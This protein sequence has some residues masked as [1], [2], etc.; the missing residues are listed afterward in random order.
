MYIFSKRLLYLFF[1]C[2]SFFEQ[3]AQ[4]SGT[5]TIPGSYSTVAAAIAD[6]NSQGVNG[7]V[8]MQVAAGY[9]ET[10]PTGGYMLTATGT[11]TAPITFQRSGI[12][13][14]PLIVAF[15]GSSTSFSNTVDCIW[16]M[17]G[18]D[19]LTIDGI[20]LLDTATS[21]PSSME[22]G[23]VFYK[24]D[25]SDGCR[26]NTVKN[27][28][29]QLSVAT[30]SNTGSCGIAFLNSTYSTN[31]TPVGTSGLDGASSYNQIFGN[32]ISKVRI[33]ITMAGASSYN[34][35]TFC[36]TGNDIGGMLAATGNTI[37]NFGGGTY[38]LQIMGV[39]TYEQFNLNL[40]NNY[41]D[42][43]TGSWVTTSGSID[44]IQLNNYRN[45]NTTILNNTVSVKSTGT[46]V[47]VNGISSADLGVAN[48]SNVLSINNNLLLNCST[49]STGNSNLTGIKTLGSPFA[50]EIKNNLLS[51]FSGS[52][53]VS[54]MLPGSTTS[55]SL[56]SN[57]VSNVTFNGQCRAVAFVSGYGSNSLT[58]KQNLFEDFV[59]TGTVNIVLASSG[60]SSVNLYIDTNTIRNVTLT[61]G[62]ARGVMVELSDGTRSIRG[63]NIYN[64]S[65]LLNSGPIDFSGITVYYGPTVISDNQIHDFSTTS[66]VSSASS[67]SGIVTTTYQ[68]EAS[69]FRN[70]IYNFN[71]G[72][73][74]A[75]LCGILA[76]AGGPKIVA[77]NLISGFTNSTAVS[78]G[79]TNGIQINAAV[80]D[81]FYN[82]VYLNTPNTSSLSGTSAVLLGGGNINLKNNILVNTSVATGTGVTC[83]IN[84]GQNTLQNYSLT[85]NC[86]LLYAGTPSSV[87]LLYKDA[88]NSIQ[89]LNGLKIFTGSVQDVLSVTENPS[90]IST[91]GSSPFFLKLNGSVPTQAES[92]ALPIVGVSTDY[93]LNTRNASNPDIGAWEDN[94]I[95]T[96]SIAPAVFGSGFTTSTTCNT[97]GRTFTASIYDI[98]GLATGSLAPRI[99]YS[100]NNGLFSSVAGVLSSGTT[101][102]GIWSFAMAYSAAPL[103]VISY[104]VVMQDA[105]SGSN[106]ASY[107]L[108]GLVATSVN[109]VTTPPTSPYSYTVNYTLSGSYSVGVAGS[110]TSVT[111]SAN[112]Y[113]NACL[114]SSVEFVLTDALYQQNESF[115]ITFS[116]NPFA[117]MTNS[118]LIRPLA[119]TTPTISGPSNATV[120]VK[121]NNARYIAIDGI[122]PSGQALTIASYY[123]TSYANKS[124]VRIVNTT[125]KNTQNVT[126]RRCNFDG[127]GSAN[128]TRAGIAIAGENAA[129]NGSDFLF[130]ENNFS[131]FTNGIVINAGSSYYQI[132]NVVIEDNVL[133]YGNYWYS[134]IQ[135]SSGNNIVI[136]RNYLNLKNYGTGSSN[137]IYIVPENGVSVTQNTIDGVYTNSGTDA[138]GITCMLGNSTFTISE[139]IIKSIKTNTTQSSSA[140]GIV[141]SNITAA[142]TPG[143][144]SNNM[145]SDIQGKSN[146][147]ISNW[148]IGIYLYQ[149]AGVNVI[150]NSVHLFGTHISDITNVSSAAVYLGSNFNSVN[151][152]NNIFRN[153]YS[154]QNSNTAT[155]YGLY[156]TLSSVASLTID[157]NIYSVGGT[158]QP[159][160]AYHNGTVNTLGALQTTLGFNLNSS[161]LQPVFVSN[162]DLHI[163]LTVPSNS[164]IDDLG[165]SLGVLMDIDNQSRSM[166]TPDVGADE[167]ATTSCTASA[168]GSISPLT[169]TACT[170]NTVIL[171]GNG[172]TPGLNAYNNWQIAT[173]SGGSY[174]NVAG[175]GSLSAYTFSATN[176]GV[177]YFTLQSGC[178]SSTLTSAE[179]T[180]VVVSTPTVTAAIS[181]A[182]LCAGST[183]TLFA[184]SGNATGFSW[185]GPAQFTAA[186]QNP[187]VGTTNYSGGIYTV[188]ALNGVCSSTNATVNLVINPRPGTLTVV[189]TGTTLCLGMSH[190]MS[191]N[192]G[193][194]PLA[195][196]FTNSGATN[197]TISLPAPYSAYYGGQKMQF[198]I[199]ASELTSNNIVAGNM[200][201]ISFFVETLGGNWANGFALQNLQI[202]IGNTSQSS[203]T[204]SFIN[205]LSIAVPS[206]SFAAQTGY[207]Y[208]QFQTPFYWDGVSNVVLETVFSNN[209][210]SNSGNTA[211]QRIGA[212]TFQSCLVYAGNNQT[213]GT[214]AAATTSNVPTTNYRPNFILNASGGTTYSWT[215][216]NGLSNTNTV[217]TVASPTTSMS[218]TVTAGT[219]SGCKTTTN[220]SVLVTTTPTITLV[221]ATATVC[222][223]SQTTLSVSG[224]QNYTWSAGATSASAAVSPTSNAVFQ[225]TATSGPCPG[226]TGTA[227]VIVNPLPVLQTLSTNTT[228][229]SGSA[230]SFTAL[231]ASNYTWTNGATGSV[232]SYAPVSPTILAVSG[233]NSLGCIAS[234]S[235]SLNPTPLPSLTISASNA[236]VCPLQSV[237]LSVSGANTYSWGS[238][239]STNNTIVVAPTSSNIYSVTGTDQLACSKTETILISTYSIPT[240]QISPAPVVVCYGQIA[241]TTA[242]GAGSYSWS[243]GSVGN[244]YTAIANSNSIVTVTVTAAITSCTN[245]ATVQIVVA[246]LPTIT[247]TGPSTLC[248]GS[249][250]VY[251][252]N[253][254]NSYVWNSSFSGAQFSYSPSI[255]S[256]LNVNGLTSQG[257]SGTTSLAISVYSLPIITVSPLSVAA[258]I[259]DVVSY[260]ATGGNSYTWAPS[261]QISNIY[262]TTVSSSGAI[263]VSG[264]GVN[265]CKNTATVNLIADVCTSISTTIESKT[266]IKVFPNPSNGVFTAY[267]PFAADRSFT[268]INSTGQNIL[269]S[270][271]QGE[272]LT[273]SLE[274]FPSGIY[275]LTF[276]TG[277][278]FEFFILTKN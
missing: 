218:Y 40:S 113:N 256:T 271:T 114:T 127:M 204:G 118:L 61:T 84:L 240:I 142:L 180:V 62:A 4:L 87:A 217:T 172:T 91:N 144:L 75:R 255:S 58:V 30:T 111:A 150:H 147:F 112:A 26:Y 77:N 33:G 230:Q 23:F 224:A 264:S 74:N 106:I 266:K 65:T 125:G 39:Y 16:K 201:G 49:G 93:A 41:I 20:D 166:S 249:G 96:D 97:S 165:A 64:F 124:Y 99:Y 232:I 78:A 70:R 239:G 190:T 56:N 66:T 159:F 194:I 43:N 251:T 54:A 262:T 226:V 170:G 212:T 47:T 51:N 185:A 120:I 22:Y 238:N 241:Q 244:T 59:G 223:G 227:T 261:L 277:N 235:L 138:T 186:V 141:L 155:T 151:L 188:N 153:S 119:Y 270:S 116:D 265:T 107:P 160:L 228:F 178:G 117:S 126:I 193:V 225:V 191:V 86:N 243:N 250:G 90:F 179:A 134:G 5:F 229:C 18:T 252:A 50:T 105:S 80:S 29:V 154:H 157:N 32:L 173:S 72:R 171:S 152:K 71:G 267:F 37:I 215:P 94:Y 274:S 209:T 8:Y 73:T 184:T 187:T 102:N 196:T 48:A 17:S 19:F 46:N 115:P 263:S 210:V 27:C 95:S 103:D 278:S 222:L 234:T 214:V 260:T 104:F 200:T 163:D 28:T 24:K 121:F 21:V 11:S 139:N 81:V 176:S 3:R 12:G 257:C 83:A 189:P 92:G 213:F 52:G 100:I 55:L 253:G 192:G 248:E 216:S 273:F 254:A 164:L 272:L 69:I 15:T 88:S 211:I 207:N 169:Y 109:S 1:F 2:I 156:S 36:D 67:V 10:A 35:G 85:S 182:T 57:T 203:L 246:P 199:L 123:Q 60:T 221:P 13:S 9:T 76:G 242:F 140:R 275:F 135:A 128:T 68:V 31:L 195:M 132:N 6:L 220:T 197:N 198:I 136:R 143:I 42:N 89:Q 44:G 146:A 130:S 133:A 25:A 158:S 206:Q 183:P 79:H 276:K 174:T 98:S 168:S 202:S 145:V 208:H 53:V 233:A 63:N 219:I 82:T 38:P 258:C 268:V 205:G 181:S 129:A 236:S 177:Y 167:F 237:T 245:L 162:T 231:G 247:I 110:F 131:D 101:T 14:N 149:L 122:D 108:A 45:S 175:T 269:Q 137:G 7:P 34:N 161:T 148:P 259:G